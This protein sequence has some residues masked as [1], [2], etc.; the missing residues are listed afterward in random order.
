MSSRC[1]PH[2]SLKQRLQHR[3]VRDPQTRCVLWTGARN[4][5]G[6]GMLTMAGRGLTTHRAAWMVARGPI[7]AGLCVC[8]RCDVRTCIN[9]DHL[10]LGTAQENMA[11]MAA[12]MRKKRGIEPGPERR[13]T[14][15]PEIMRIEMLGREFVTRVLAI[16][17]LARDGFPGGRPAPGPRRRRA[18]STG[19]L[20]ALNQ[21]RR[22]RRA[23]GDS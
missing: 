10:F 2:W 3:S 19:S 9:P 14:K 16:R 5:H 20:R 15:S 13:P 22:R 8:H 21:P 1:P 23:A 4:G 18:T 11:D 12:K 7:P 6:Y 17:T